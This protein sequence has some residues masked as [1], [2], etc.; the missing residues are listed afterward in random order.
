MVWASNAAM[1]KGCI[2]RGS[3]RK[4]VEASRLIR[5]VQEHVRL[6]NTNPGHG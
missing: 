3:L 1:T 4:S 6:A 5:C 2:R